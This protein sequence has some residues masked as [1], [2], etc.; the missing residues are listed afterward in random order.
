[1]FFTT[2]A[3]FHRYKQRQTIDVSPCNPRS[4]GNWKAALCAWLPHISSDTSRH[5]HIL[6]P[7]GLVRVSFPDYTWYNQRCA[8]W[9]LAFLN[10]RTKDKIKSMN[11]TALYSSVSSFLFS[12]ITQVIY[13]SPFSFSFLFEIIVI[14]FCRLLT[15]FIK[16]GNLQAL[17]TF[18][19][20]RA[21]KTISVIP[22]KGY[23]LL[24]SRK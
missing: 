9:L 6:T 15:E 5:D 22:G 2:P 17:R 20:L 16:V 4:Y 12:P 21:L 11:Y 10:P 24:H 13:L 7:L 3:L 1:M 18:R 8:Q 14:W 19:V 23:M